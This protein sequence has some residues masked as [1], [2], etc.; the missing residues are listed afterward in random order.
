MKQ[1]ILNGLIEYNAKGSYPWHMP[2]HKRRLQTIFPEIIDKYHKSDKLMILKSKKDK[3]DFLEQCK[4][5]FL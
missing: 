4:Y 2:G 5:D 1:S 3:E